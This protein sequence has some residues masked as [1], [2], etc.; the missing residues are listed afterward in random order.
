MALRLEDYAIIG[1]TRTAAL[2]GKDGSID[3]LCLPRFD[4]GACFAALLGE[5]EHGRWLVAPA[6]GVR[7]TAR[8]YRAG[9]LVLETEFTTE[10]GV[11][12]VVDCMPPAESIPNVLRLVE[13]VRG[14]VA[15]RMELITRFDYGWVV[16]WTR[17]ENG[18]LLAVGGPDAL[19]LQTP[20]ELTDGGSRTVAEFMVAEGE[21]VPFVLSWFPSHEGPPDSIDVIRTVADAESWWTAWSRKCA[22]EGPWKEEVIGSL[23]TL[24]ALTYLPTGGIVAAVTT[25]LPEALGGMRNWDYRFCWLRDATFT[26]YALL[27]GGHRKEASA[28]RDWLL[29]AVAG[30]PGQLQILYGVAG[31]RRNPELTLDWLPGYEGS[32]PVRIG[33]AAADQL[34]L[35]VYG[36]VSDVL[37]QGR[38][39][40]IPADPSAWAFQRRMLDFLEGAWQ[41]PD[42]GIWEVRGPR[43]DFTHSKI[44]AWVAFDRAIKT[45]ERFGLEGPVDRWRGQRDLIHREVCERGFDRDKNAFTQAYGSG[46]LDASLLMT[47]LVGFLPATDERVVGTVR[48]I[49][50][51]LLESGLV[52]RYRTAESNDGLPPGEGA[53]LACSFWLA[54]NYALMGRRED[55]LALFERLL[56]L[57]NDV[58]LLS[59]EYDPVARRLLGNFPQAFS[60]VGLVNTAFN[61]T[62]RQRAPASERHED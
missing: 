15:M 1:D 2:V 14:R 55:A 28:W 7:S 53:F 24:K 30:A 39:H 62:P 43:R 37:Y 27:L 12:R 49:E 19:V 58:G 23:V 5:P 51:E 42:E 33:N 61:L 57:R 34:Q 56:S 46:N 29:R 44:M 13:G 21:S 16:P 52:L 32:R 54:D 4:S 10:S 47:A 36:E 18:A 22:Y 3:W 50:R 35:D 60:H 59:E 40:G 31:E 25:S 20:V 26:L 48:A 8:R 45:C 38:K 6:G 17:R 41:E 11:V 9:T